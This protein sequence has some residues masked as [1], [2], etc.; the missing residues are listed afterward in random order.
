MWCDNENETG[1]SVSDEIKTDHGHATD[2]MIEAWK[3]HMDRTGRVNLSEFIGEAVN[4][5]IASECKRGRFK[6]S[7][8]GERGVKGIRPTEA[9]TK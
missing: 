1:E 3:D 4:T 2:C 8:K 5:M 7:V 6:N 9:A